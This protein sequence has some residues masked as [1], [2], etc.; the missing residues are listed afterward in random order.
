MKRRKLAVTAGCVGLTVCI[1]SQSA[2]I[3]LAAENIQADSAAAGI[4]VALNGYMNKGENA[5]EDIKAYLEG[6]G[7]LKSGIGSLAKEDGEEPVSLYENLAIS[8]VTDYVNIRSEASTESEI[9]GKIY[10]Q[11]AATILDTVEK[12]DGTWYHIKSGS[13]T[14]YMKAEFFVTGFE[15]EEYAKA[16]SNM[17]T[18][19]KEGGLRVR[20]E[21]S[22]DSEVLTMLYEGETCTVLEDGGEFVKVRMED[23][24]EGYVYGE[25]VEIYI[26]CDE[27]ISLEEEQAMIEEQQRL[28]REAEEARQAELA[29]QQA[30][31][32]QAQAQN[33]S[34]SGGNSSGGGSAP[35][36]APAPEYN[37]PANVGDGSAARQAVVDYALSKVGC[38][39][40]WGAEGPNAFDCSGLVKCAYAQVGVYLSHYSGSQGAAGSYRSLSEA[41]PGDILWKN[42]HVGIYIGG[43]QYVHASTYGVGVIVSN[44]SS[45]GFS[46]ARNVLG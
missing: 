30:A 27:A 46:C 2:F 29:R 7:T 41:Q 8:K 45:S 35:A 44:V 10:D 37:P 43:G 36:P 33:N 15:A 42:G 26:E 40:V 5:T 13:V 24:T 32:Q 17:Y 31:Q 6:T 16:N 4:S 28:E 14:G 20:S 18:R 9:L 3:S 23:G 39:Y 25:Y 34:N 22:L 12:E 1:L 38:E 19:A 21:A 11:C